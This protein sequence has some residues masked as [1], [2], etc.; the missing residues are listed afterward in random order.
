MRTALQIR[1]LR[2]SK[3]LTSHALPVAQKIKLVLPSPGNSSGSGW[4]SPHYTE[5]Q[6]NLYVK[7]RG[8]EAPCNYYTLFR[9]S[10]LHRGHY[11]LEKVRPRM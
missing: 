8:T 7:K 9:I 1:H 4:F 6:I 11:S 3:T 10:V 2:K 5:V